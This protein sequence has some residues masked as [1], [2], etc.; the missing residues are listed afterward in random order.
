MKKTLLSV[1]LASAVL[2]MVG[3]AEIPEGVDAKFF[4]SGYNTFVEIDDDTMELENSDR[5][6]LANIQLIQ[7][8]A[9][10]KREADFLNG[11]EGMAKLQEKVIN[12]D[13]DALSE[14]MKA[15]KLAMDALNLGDEGDSD[16]F[17]VNPFQFTEDN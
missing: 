15:R 7:V 5:D 3:C 10:T 8:N 14:Y 2:T 13:V 4:E 12:H 6:D 9:N 17:S 1:L 16:K 11:L